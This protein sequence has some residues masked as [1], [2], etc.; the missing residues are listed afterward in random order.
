MK[1]LTFSDFTG[2][3]Q[4]SVSPDDFTDRQWAELRGIVPTDQNTFRSQWPSQRLGDQ[5]PTGTNKDFNAVFPLESSAGTFIVGIKTNGSIWWAKSP[6]TTAEY[7]TA[8]AVVW[9]ELTGTDSSNYGITTSSAATPVNINIERNPDYRFIAGFNFE[10]YKYI[11]KP[12][13]GSNGSP[14][15]ASDFTQDIL[16][17]D[18]E[19]VSTGASSVP[20]VLINC[21]RQRRFSGATPSFKMFDSAGNV[22]PTRLNQILAVYVDPN[23][24]VVGGSEGSVRVVVFP[25]LRRWPTYTHNY[26]ATSATGTLLYPDGWPQAS[27]GGITYGEETRAAPIKAWFGKKAVPQGES[28]A[29]TTE[30]PFPSSANST[31]P[32]PLTAFHPYTYLDLNSTLAPGRG[33]IP[34]GNVG[35][36]WNN[37]LILG[38]I[39]Y[40]SDKALE[41]NSTSRKIKVSPNHATLGLPALNDSNTEEHRG[42]F[43][44]ANSAID[45]FDPRN[46]INV[47]SADARIAGIHALDNYLIC[48]TTKAG[49]D[50]GVFA[51]SGNLGDLISYRGNSNPNALKKQI[52]R[53]GVGVADYETDAQARG[54]G[55]IT[56][57]CVW[58]EVGNVVFIDASGSIYSTNGRT[59]D[60]IDL[61]GPKKPVKSVF[62]DHVAAVTNHLV[63]WRDG[64]LLVLSVLDSDGT[65]ASACWTEIVPPNDV[66]LGNSP[67]MIKSMIGSGTQLFMVVNGSVW[68]YCTDGPATEFGKIDGTLHDIYISTASLGEQNSHS[69]TNWF[70][71]GF[72]F[73]VNESTG[74]TATV[75]FV[76]IKGEAMLY[77]G[78]DAA[79]YLVTPAKVYGKGHHEFV[80]PAGVGQQSVM[81][82]RLSIKGDVTIKGFTVWANGGIMDYGDKT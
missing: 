79:E 48:I 28:K 75:S 31:Y 30:Y 38:D 29:F 68:R 7:T 10:V 1:K 43:Y 47:T 32:D 9:T 23:D 26:S 64:K 3:I 61:H 24:K 67:S 45:E 51:Y 6:A 22:I 50:D 17:L 44:Y 16:P 55:H 66:L 70:R 33:I 12:L 25:H 46:V 49:P 4:E 60:R 34:R 36:V 82:A 18:N 35:A 20:A 2:G 53:G 65:T 71:V 58:P 81:S 41:A 78:I 74:N 37:R 15:R 59:C 54:K 21:R 56:Q 72:S 69:K 39:E 42:S 76:K 77:K 57:S 8:R 80:C 52:I 11:K 5:G 27:I 73:Y 19:D 63:A 14:S 13:R 62:Y 40:R